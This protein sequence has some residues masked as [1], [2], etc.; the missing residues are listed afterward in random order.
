M[1]EAL[2]SRLGLVSDTL[3]P[4]S[5]GPEAP[6]AQSLRARLLQSG[7]LRP[8]VVKALDALV[9][10]LA[11]QEGTST[12]LAGADPAAANSMWGVAASSVRGPAPAE[13]AVDSG[14]GGEALPEEQTGRYTDRRA[15]AKGGMGEILIVRDQALARDVAWKQLPDDLKEFAALMETRA[16]P[17]AASLRNRFLQEARIAGQLEH[18]SI[19]PVYELGKRANGEPYY[20][21]KFVRGMTLSEA[22]RNAKNL[23]ARLQLLPHF[24]DLCNAIAYAHSR[25][26][27]HRDIKP[28]N[29]MVGDFGETVVLDWGLAKVAGEREED[30]AER[31]LSLRAG[32]AKDEKDSSRTAYGEALG[33]PAYMS[34]EQA[35]GEL[36]AIDKRSDVYS[37]GA[38]LYVLLTG[39]PPFSGMNAKSVV[40]QV[41][42]YEPVR[43]HTLCPQAP[44][45]L[46]AIC[47]A[48]MRRNK[49][50]RY[51]SAKEV[52]D[53][54]TRFQA[55]A[56]VNAHT[57]SPLERLS[58]LFQTYR[59]PLMTG[60]VALLVLMVASFGYTI[61]LSLANLMLE[62]SR[63]VEMAQR[64]A[65]ESAQR[66]EREVRAAA[67]EATHALT[68][69]AYAS[70]IQLSQVNLNALHA[71]PA[72]AR[73]FDTVSDLRGWEWGHLYQ[74][75]DES[76]LTIAGHAD[77][78]N[79]AVS[80]HDET[81]VV[82][83][84]VDATAK[85][86]DAGDGKE[87]LTLRG[88]GD[89]VFVARF[90]RDDRRVVTASRDGTAM[91]WDA[92]SGTELLRFD[93]HTDLVS[94]L[95]IDHEGQRAVTGS[96]DRRVYVWDLDT[97]QVI[98][99]YRGHGS[100]VRDVAFI[101]GG[102]QVVS[103][104]NDA[105]RIWDTETGE[106]RLGIV[107]EHISAIALSP[108][109]TRMAT[110]RGSDDRIEIRSLATGAVLETLPR[111]I[112]AANRIAFSPD[113][114]QL[115]IGSKNHIIR[116]WDLAAAADVLALVG[117]AGRI[118]S[119]HFSRNG[120]E[121]IS[122]SDDRTVKR[123]DLEASRAQV[124]TLPPDQRILDVAHGDSRQILVQDQDERAQVLDPATGTMLPIGPAD[125]AI[126]S[127]SFS[128][129][130]RLAG[131]I[132][133]AGAAIVWDIPSG[134]ALHTLPRKSG[135]SDLVFSD[136][137]TRALTIVRNRVD[138]WDLESGVHLLEIK[139]HSSDLN[140]ARFSP[141]GDYV[142]T[143]SKDRRA[144]VWDAGSGELLLRLP[145]H[146]ANVND[147]TFSADGLR[148]AT[149]AENLAFLWDR[150]SG[151][152]MHRFDGH[153]DRIYRVSFNPEGD[154]VITASQ[155][156]FAKIWDAVS[157]RELLSLKL[158]PSGMK[159][160]WYADDGRR[161]VAHT[162]TSVRHWHS[163]PWRRSDWLDD[164]PRQ[165]LRR[166]AARNARAIERIDF[167]PGT[168]ET[169]AMKLAIA[170]LGAAWR[171]WLPDDSGSIRELPGEGI[172]VVRAS[173]LAGIPEL[174]LTDGDLITAVDRVP[175]FT[176][177][178]AGT[179]LAAAAAQLQSDQASREITVEVYNRFSARQLHLSF[180][181]L[182]EESI[183]IHRGMMQVYLGVARTMLA[184][185][186][187]DREDG[188]FEDGEPDQVIRLAE[189][190]TPFGL[191][192]RD[193]VI[194]VNDIRIQN[195][196]HLV[197]T[198]S[199]LV[200]QAEQGALSAIA[201]VVRRPST[202]EYIRKTIQM[203]D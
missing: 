29:V 96:R 105:I 44:P 58:R 194:S 18:P 164:A 30:F 56:F 14:Q 148:V 31:S 179:R 84:S 199:E 42:A 114:Q 8:G 135:L 28:A 172:L 153:L 171:A 122:A 88:H 200:D 21:M 51:D 119:V 102:R 165:I 195:I 93:R 168:A 11:S 158:P 128:A 192:T 116:I 22:V 69:T 90:T 6:A 16:D 161:V 134:R 147:A 182:V 92:R 104:C 174:R 35:A 26:V 36:S 25:G 144:K 77:A 40:R 127:G 37:L 133:A 87:L 107:D 118:Q 4:A 181:R 101:A 191:E 91:V 188:A 19:V 136:D 167:P 43:I 5:A 100:Y 120:R 170:E 9:D 75:L 78:V 61:Q 79:F 138:L 109:G 146:D 55:G 70:S 20:T 132:S 154:R 137:G 110:I 64:K 12:S 50:A 183:E 23:E 83:A 65:L 198:T 67:E 176:V 125:T 13:T 15:Y 187:L 38:V 202:N 112:G 99:E 123:W 113:G 189:L 94:S 68:R 143:A 177:Y 108:D 157:G 98:H 59:T 82:T 126:V 196:Q 201:I 150:S 163:A 117:H 49:D 63:D 47:E 95:D 142:V 27:I 151:E 121:L 160:A 162:D 39:R 32:L 111:R 166:L 62:E 7:T 57:Y 45:E 10:D 97:G 17:S 89:K 173:A 124:Y 193:E 106:E 41:L 139:G 52:A 169:A 140:R 2:A 115:A 46:V 149:A 1:F 3:P 24:V 152:M 80:S 185:I 48:A 66:D 54:V 186:G 81:R 175:V 33:T 141:G 190:S 34:P 155:D 103:R 60:L 156:G 159:N 86:W 74:A 76:V 130:G 73:L 129:N 197:A 85:I 131:L 145:R 178:A 203:T 71:G 180:P 53:E 184:N 72:R